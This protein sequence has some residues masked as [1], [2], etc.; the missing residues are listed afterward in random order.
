MHH[1]ARSSRHRVPE[2]ML[3][4][5]V[6][7]SFRPDSKLRTDR[8]G[9]GKSQRLP[10]CRAGEPL[11]SH[12]GCG[13]VS[14]RTGGRHSAGGYGGGL[15]TKALLLRLEGAEF[16]DTATEDRQQKALNFT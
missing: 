9:R 14:P 7:Y 3:E 13:S 12:R 6:A 5:T 11:Q 2:A 4:R 8:P 10:G 15:A 16:R 1:S